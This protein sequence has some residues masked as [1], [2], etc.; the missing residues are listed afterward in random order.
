MTTNL[1]RFIH[2]LVEQKKWLSITTIFVFT[3]VI[4]GGLGNVAMRIG[5][6]VSGGGANNEDE[7]AA[8]SPS[9]SSFLDSSQKAAGK[10]GN[11]KELPAIAGVTEEK[12]IFNESQ[13]NIE[14][15]VRQERDKNGQAT[16]F[17]CVVPREDFDT[18]TIWYKEKMGVDEVVSLRFSLKSDQNAKNSDQAPKLILSYGKRKDGGIYYRA[19]FPDTDT[20]RVDFED[21][22]GKKVIH[23]KSKLPLPLDVANEKEVELKY[24]VKSLY[25]NEAV[26]HYELNYIP[27]LGGTD[28][29]KIN[30]VPASDSFQSSFP[31]PNPRSAGAEQEIGIGAYPGT[32]FKII[33]FSKTPETESRD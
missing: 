10:N 22:S 21:F 12:A 3:L 16:G 30:Q 23:T 6:I 4:F 14:K 7:L 31:W 19:F 15:G 9:V 8:P 2:E 33:S 20:D 32:C 18:S 29:E 1:A 28:D 13:W 26:F 5:S 24:S 25:S 11:A 17:Y 27:E